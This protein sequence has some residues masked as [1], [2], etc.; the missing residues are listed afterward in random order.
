MASRQLTGNTSAQK[1]AETIDEALDLLEEVPATAEE[2]PDSAL[3]KAPASLLEECMELCAQYEAITPEP[4]RTIHHFACTGGTLISKCL[5]A[6]PNTQ[7]LSE[8][9]PLSTMEAGAPQKPRFAPTDMIQQMRQSTRGADDEMLIELFLNNMDQIHANSENKGQRI[10]IRDHAHSH[11]CTGPDIH[12]RPTLRDMLA[13][14]FP[15]ASVVTV[16]HPLDSYLSLRKQNW[17]GGVETLDEY[18]RRY[19]AFLDAYSDAPIVKY[20]DFVRDPERTMPDVCE[21]LGLPYS[22]DFEYLQT[23][24]KLTGDSGRSGNAISPRPRRPVADEL[25]SEKRASD[26]YGTLVEKLHYRE[27]TPCC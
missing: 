14:K 17:A 8:V 22:S 7:L 3:K 6:M 13:R 20:E 25:M 1:L 24:F 16:R 4:I 11:F 26:Q 9:D 10:V 15:V 23:V 5:A 12:E 21:H 2:Q 18:C 19:L 27:K